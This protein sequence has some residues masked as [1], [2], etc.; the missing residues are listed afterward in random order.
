M[1]AGGGVAGRRT[2]A[3]R[4]LSALR[5]SPG[6]T[7]AWPTWWLLLAFDAGVAWSEPSSSATVH[8]PDT[9]E[10]V[11]AQSS[12]APLTS[13]TWSLSCIQTEWCHQASS[14]TQTQ[15]CPHGQQSCSGKL[16]SGRFVVRAAHGGHPS[17]VPGPYHGV[18]EGAPSW[19]W[20]PPKYYPSCLCPHAG[21]MPG[22]SFRMMLIISKKKKRNSKTIP[23]PPPILLCG[24]SLRCSECVS[25]FFL[26]FILF[27]AGRPVC[28]TGPSCVELQHLGPFWKKT[29][30]ECFLTSE[31]R[32][33]VCRKMEWV[34]ENYEREM[35]FSSV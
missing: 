10:R 24:M 26:S 23:S 15:P 29:K 18:V 30:T 19:P 2:E 17:R 31:K 25:V 33:G 4:A 5:G 1:G 3:C 21:T 16:A 9:Q 27:L 14:D 34:T 35:T 20:C 28:E 32:G 13:S 22:H 6:P 7:G 12:S 8:L 11:P